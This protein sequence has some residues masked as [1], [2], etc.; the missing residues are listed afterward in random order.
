MPETPTRP[1][2]ADSDASPRDEPRTAPQPDL[3]QQ[4]ARPS[5]PEV[6]HAPNEGGSVR[7]PR[8]QTPQARDAHADQNRGSL[9]GRKEKDLG[10]EAQTGERLGERGGRLGA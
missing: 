8:L 5:D 4:E 10:G 9:A 1:H 7:D 3:K 6:A 2:S